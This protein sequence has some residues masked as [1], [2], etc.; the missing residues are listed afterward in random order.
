M[1][2]TFGCIYFMCIL[3][4]EILNVTYRSGTEKLIKVNFMFEAN[5]PDFRHQ[6]RRPH[7]HGQTSSDHCLQIGHHSSCMIFVS[8]NYFDECQ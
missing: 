8:L 1:V 2:E 4:V 7:L 3:A 6:K 5:K